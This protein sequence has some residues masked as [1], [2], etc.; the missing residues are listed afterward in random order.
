MSLNFQNKVIQLT[1]KN[2]FH[3]DA[4]M[5]ESKVEELKSRHLKNRTIINLFHLRTC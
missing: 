3:F 2:M 1:L 5:L 4:N